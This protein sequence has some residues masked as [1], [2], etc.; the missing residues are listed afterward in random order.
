MENVNRLFVP[1]NSEAF[2]WFKLGKTWEVRT[3]KG[4]YNLTN[5]KVGRKVELRRGYNSNDS[6][7]GTISEVKVFE[8]AQDLLKLID[9]KKIL[10]TVGSFQ[11]AEFLIEKFVSTNDKIIAFKIKQN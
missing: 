9:Y 11:E 10:P 7:W 1:L 8:N 4:Q 6:L 5:I 2:S 3:M